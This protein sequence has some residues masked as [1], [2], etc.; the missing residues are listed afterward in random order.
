MFIS[1]LTGCVEQYHNAITPHQTLLTTHGILEMTHSNSHEYYYSDRY[2]P[3]PG[4]RRLLGRRDI[5]DTVTWRNDTRDPVMAI[6]RPGQH[7][8][9]KRQICE[10]TVTRWNDRRTVMQYIRELWPISDRDLRDARDPVAAGSNFFGQSVRSP[11]QLILRLFRPLT[12][13]NEWERT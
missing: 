7:V 13:C 11:W 2:R 5:W 3:G 8:G 4:Q 1:D 12:Q 9:T 6:H 10:V